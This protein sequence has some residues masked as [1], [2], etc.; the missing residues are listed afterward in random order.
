MIRFDVLTL[1]PGIFESYLRESLL[2][3]AIAAGLVQVHTWNIRDWTRDKHH[4]VDD[5]PFGGGP[6]MVMMAQPVVDAVEAV[7]AKGELP[8]ALVM[9]TP[10]GERL[11]QRTVERLAALPRLLLL[12]GKYEG[13][14]DRIRQILKPW[15]ISVGDFVCNGGEVPAM[16]IIDSVIRLI[17]GVLGDETSAAD[18]SHSEP[19][20]LEYPQYTRPRVFRGLEVPE[21]LVSGNHAAVAKWRQEQ[22]AKRSDQVSTGGTPVPPT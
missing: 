8:G 2:D 17:P 12:C 15:E 14:D 5:R 1:F 10:V 7:Q 4:K 3:D 11:T 21:V 13:F 20:R 19:G 22:S 9:L 18:E 16:V 6:G